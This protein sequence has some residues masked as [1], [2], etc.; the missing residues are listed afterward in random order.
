MSEQIWS[1]LNMMVIFTGHF[2]RQF[3]KCLEIAFYVFYAL[4]ML[5]PTLCPCDYVG[6]EVGGDGVFWWVNIIYSPIIFRLI[7]W[8]RGDHSLSGSDM[9]SNGTIRFLWVVLCCVLLCF[10]AR[11]SSQ[12]KDGLSMYVDSLYKDKTVLRPSYLYNG[13]SYTSRESAK[14]Q[15]QHF[16]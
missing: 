8:H 15:T 4:F 5:M 3:V 1:C 16:S 13:D 2:T 11:D 14:T 7:Q 9:K 10:G 6:V 12:Y